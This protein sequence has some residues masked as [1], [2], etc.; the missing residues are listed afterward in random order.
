MFDDL[1]LSEPAQT[2]L[3]ALLDHGIDGRVRL[4]MI[5]LP[6]LCFNRRNSW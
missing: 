3:R 6:A 1:F 5:M 2:S 4:N